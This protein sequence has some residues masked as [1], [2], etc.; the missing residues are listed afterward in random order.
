[1]AAFPFAAV[2]PPLLRVCRLTGEKIT[3]ILLF[4]FKNVNTSTTAAAVVV[5]VIV[6]NVIIGIEFE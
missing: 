2:S 4:L 1:M 5:N 3:L 6:I